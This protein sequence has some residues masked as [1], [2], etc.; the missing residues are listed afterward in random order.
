MASKED[1][2]KF[3]EFQEKD[4]ES[5][6]CFECGA[7]APQWC[8]L[9]HGLFVCLECSGVHRSLGTH[10]S[11]VRSLTMDGWQPEKLKLMLTG[12]NGKA[13]AF[14]K[15]KGIADLP[16][17]EK[18]ATDGALMYKDKLAAE[19]AGKV[20]KESEWKPPERKQTY[21]SQAQNQARPEPGFGGS[22]YGGIG[23]ASNNPKPSDSWGDATAAL[24]K[25]WSS[26]SSA[27]SDAATVAAAKA[28]EASK[29]AQE[30]ASTWQGSGWTAS[31]GQAQGGGEVGEAV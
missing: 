22:K 31:K 24:S 26:F 8:A 6:V 3:R 1:L 14:F 25:G 11:F 23:A 10:L 5:K 30:S 16:I 4:K 2:A 28:Q 17:R 29:A 18:Y 20:F 19:A 15:A 7:H 12:G 21:V 27:V 13:K 9:L